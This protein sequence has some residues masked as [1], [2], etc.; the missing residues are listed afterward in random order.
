MK[1]VRLFL[2]IFLN[3]LILSIFMLNSSCEDDTSEAPDDPNIVDTPDNLDEDREF[4]SPP[5]LQQPIYECAQTVVVKNF[6]V[7]ATLQVFVDGA[8]EGTETGIWTGG[9]PVQLGTALTQGQKVR[10]IQIVDGVSS[11]SSNQVTVTSYL[12]DYPGGLPR[13]RIS[14]SPLLKCG[15]AIGIEDAVPGAK[16][17]A[18]AENP[19]GAGFDPAVQIGSISDFGY[20][21]VTSLQ[22]GARVWLDQTLCDETSDRSPVEIV[23]PEPGTIPTPVLDPL[24]IEG[25]DIV[26]FWGS[27]GNPDPLLNGATLEIS[28]GGSPIGG[29]PTPGGGQQVLVSPK[30]VAGNTYELIQKLCNSSLP[31]TTTGQPCSSLNAPTIYP[32]QPG[33]ISVELI[34]YYP[35]AQIL[36]FADGVEIGHSGPTVI[37]LSRPIAEGENIIVVQKLGNC[38]GSTAYGTTAECDDRNRNGACGGDWPA[39]RQ[40]AA[41]DGNQPFSVEL[42]KGEKVKK[43][44]V[45]HTF[46]P[47][48]SLPQGFTASPIVYKDKVFI[49]GSNGRLYALRA[50]DLGYLWE[51]PDPDAD[52]KVS[53][54]QYNPSSW[55]IASSA[56]IGII[57]EGELEAV[58][59]GAPDNKFGTMNGSGRLFALDVNSGSPIW[60][61]DEVAILDGVSAGSYTELHEQIGYS[62]P[63]VYNNRVYIGIANHSDNPIQ[64]GKV[65]AVELNSGNIIGSFLFEGAGG[66]DRE[67]NGRGGGVWNSPAGG[68]SGGVYFTTGNTKTSS[69]TAEPSPNHGLSLIKVDEVSGSLVWKLQPVP[70][71]ADGDPDWAAGAL[72]AQTACGEMVLSTMKDGWAY[73]VDA[74][75]SGAVVPAQWQFPSTGA[76]DPITGNYFKYMDGTN[77]GDIRYLVAGAAWKSTYITM[78]G[79]EEVTD[80]V[81]AGFSRLHSLSACNG[82]VR[83]IAN[84]PGVAI[85]SPYQLGPPTVTKGIVFVGTSQGRLVAL[86]DPSVY[87]SAKSICSDQNYSVEDCIAN[88]GTIVKE[89]IELLNLPIGE[90]AMFRNEPVIANDK[91]YISTLSG[92]VVMLEVVE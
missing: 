91:I 78:T 31:G 65:K 59:F 4:I 72:V 64:K 29:Q 18:Y 49:G 44:Q 53:N 63:L 62:S 21:F 56:S 19:N 71:A 66:G 79:G 11:D 14:R 17:V 5:T 15:R 28:E 1:S 54:Y 45:T 81:N 9:A 32:P 39:F 90:G 51:F 76:Y 75:S 10:A 22:E 88:G 2:I 16:V 40:G 52:P 70:Y 80:N 46:S 37:N 92:N 89:P 55:G 50:N 87:V 26:V 35:G 67:P 58:I 38:I 8:L 13:P 7:G 57:Q 77:H 23:D 82:V 20:M 34:S 48:E 41:R 61:S 42:A 24:P 12:E 68:Y 43:L 25:A 84:I 47:D 36:V 60:Q 33:D 86:A 30:I 73:G 69:Q 83:W 85:N 74:S 3:V 6:I 27:G